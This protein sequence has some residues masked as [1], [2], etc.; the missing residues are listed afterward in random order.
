MKTSENNNGK[1]WMIGIAIIFLLS[2]SSSSIQAQEEKPKL[3]FSGFGRTYAGVL[4]SNGDLTILQNT[5]DLTLK[6]R[7]K[8][9][10]F[11]ANAFYYQYPYQQDYFGIRELYMDIFTKKVDIR[12]GKQQIVW[13]QADGVFITDIVSPLNLT[14]FLLWDFNEI[15]M[16][17]TAI[18]AKFYPHQN[19]NFE[20]VYIPVFMP[21]LA[22]AVGTIWR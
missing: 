20:L 6:Y 19:H 5:L 15:R 21:T 11:A 14:E 8:K 12:I 7:R 9:V 4:Y 10:G 2:F 13:G 1:F 3:D 16:G 18:K 17:V 22:P